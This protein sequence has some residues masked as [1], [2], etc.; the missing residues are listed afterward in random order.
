MKKQHIKTG[1]EFAPMLVKGVGGGVFKHVIRPEM[2]AKRGWIAVG[3]VV[4]AHE[5][6]CE[7]GETLSEGADKALESHPVATSLAI[8]YTALHLLNKIPPKLDVFNMLAVN[9]KPPHIGYL[10]NAEI[11]AQLS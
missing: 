6:L 9:Y 2:T 4:G 8:G 10:T 11:D 7:A 5:L 1:I 3:I